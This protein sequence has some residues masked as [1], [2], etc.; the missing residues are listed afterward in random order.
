MNI[1]VWKAY[2]FT[3][4]AI[5][6]VH[7][8]RLSARQLVQIVC[9]NGHRSTVASTWNQHRSV[10]YSVLANPFVIFTPNYREGTA[11]CHCRSQIQH[12]TH[13]VAAQIRRWATHLPM[14]P[15]LIVFRCPL[16]QLWIRTAIAATVA[17]PHWTVHCCLPCAKW[18]LLYV[19][20]IELNLLHSH[21]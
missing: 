19:S 2:I 5:A 11:V 9:L 3:A 20:R 21:F 16:I 13:S 12:W 6:K 8:P 15:S 7:Q 4:A 17:M 14:M 1:L 18:T 10:R